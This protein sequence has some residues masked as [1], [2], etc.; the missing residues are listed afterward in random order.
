MATQA[1]DRGGREMLLKIH[2][3]SNLSP[4]TMCLCH[5]LGDEEQLV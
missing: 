1:S 3:G 2:L 5:E 4:I